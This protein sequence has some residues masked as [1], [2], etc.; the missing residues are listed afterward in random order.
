[1]NTFKISSE[2]TTKIS[3]TKG[4]AI[5]ELFTSEGCASCPPADELLGRILKESDGRGIYILAYHVDYWDRQGWKD[6]FS[7]SDFSKRQRQYARWLNMSSLYTPQLIINGDKEFVGSQESSIRKEI[8]KQIS[9][10][11]KASLE[12]QVRLDDQKL[13]IRYHTKGTKKDSL[14]TAL[15]QR[16]AETRVERGENAGHILSHVQI[17]RK[18]QTDP[19]NDVGEGIV[20]L[21][22]PNDFNPQ[23]GEIICFV[24]DQ[25]NGKISAAAGAGLLNKNQ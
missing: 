24:Q 6:V 15:V 2:P 19:L 10:N 20:T 9:T 21:E 8:S 3:D 5:L 25:S 22:L 4:F 23:K 11:S 17:V 7:S 18:I 16:S 14:V 13:S 12:I 1:M